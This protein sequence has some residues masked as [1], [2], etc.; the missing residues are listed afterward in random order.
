MRKYVEQRAGGG[1]YGSVSEYIR[2]L[3]RRDQNLVRRAPMIN[4]SAQMPRLA[5]APEPIESQRPAI[6]REPAEPPRL[7]IAARANDRFGRGL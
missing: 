5:I 3:I 7:A 6:T 4:E 2:E 1:A